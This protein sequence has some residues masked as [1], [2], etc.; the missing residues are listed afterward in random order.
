[1]YTLLHNSHDSGDDF[2]QVV[3]T[4]SVSPTTDLLGTALTDTKTTVLISLNH[5]VTVYISSV[6]LIVTKDNSTDIPQ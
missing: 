5:S 3:E 6:A 1:M 2:A 4:R